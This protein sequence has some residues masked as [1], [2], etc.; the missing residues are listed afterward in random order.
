MSD[1]ETVAASEL[2]SATNGPQGENDA[3]NQPKTMEQ[4]KVRSAA[5][6]AWRELRRNPLFWI[7]LAITLCIL[8]MAF[9]PSLFTSADP[10]ACDLK[11]QMGS[12][13]PGAP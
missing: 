12:P 2:H 6:D 8:L 9:W 11:N 3:P 1:F 4:A 13:G 10:Q 7:A 5:A